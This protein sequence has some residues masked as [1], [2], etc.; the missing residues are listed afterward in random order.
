MDALLADFGDS[1]KL[2]AKWENHKRGD[3]NL[4]YGP[5]GIHRITRGGGGSRISNLLHKDV[6]L[7]VESEDSDNSITNESDSA[8]STSRRP[9]VTSFTISKGS[10][11]GKQKDLQCYC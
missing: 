7:Q 1:A 4:G 3:R 5:T 9:K 8:I 2:Y 6:T 10:T 11:D